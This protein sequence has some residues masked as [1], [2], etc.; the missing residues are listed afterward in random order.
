MKRQD[1]ES[2]HQKIIITS[3]PEKSSR[4]SD[5]KVKENSSPLLSNNPTDNVVAGPVEVFQN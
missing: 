5:K 1:Q 3:T 2:P 4:S